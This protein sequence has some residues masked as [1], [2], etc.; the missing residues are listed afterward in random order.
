ML[1]WLGPRKASEPPDGGSGA[2]AAAPNGEDVTD[3]PLAAIDTGQRRRGPRQ[4]YSV[5][6][7]V[8]LPRV[9]LKNAVPAAS[10]TSGGG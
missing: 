8:Y 3:D 4:I 9:S 7:S 5:S 2:P 1:R 6:R 10:T